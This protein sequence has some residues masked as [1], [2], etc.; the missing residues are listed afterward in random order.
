LWTHNGNKVAE[1]DL[2]EFL[3]Y[4]QF[5]GRSEIEVITGQLTVHQMTSRDSGTYRSIIT[6]NGKL[7]NSD[8]EVKVIGK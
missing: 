8:N 2:T 4:G 1:N 5:K 3:E 7:Q 6:I